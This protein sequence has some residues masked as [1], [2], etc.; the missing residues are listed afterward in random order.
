[1]LITQCER[2]NLSAPKFCQSIGC[3]LTS[4]YQWK[5]K[6]AALLNVA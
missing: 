6:L 5:R 4:F 1:M 3:S 2:S